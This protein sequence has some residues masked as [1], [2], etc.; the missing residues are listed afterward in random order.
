MGGRSTAGVLESRVRRREHVWNPGCRPPAA[1]ADHEAERG[2]WN[3]AAEEARSL[4]V[5]A[6][7]SAGVLWEETTASVSKGVRG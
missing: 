7:Q 1:S 5:D 3:V 4:D 6:V 2:T